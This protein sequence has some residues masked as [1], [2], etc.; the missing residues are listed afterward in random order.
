MGLNEKVV[1]TAIRQDLN[2]VSSAIKTGQTVTQK[3]V[4]QGRTL[5]YNAHKLPNGTVNVGRIHA[6]N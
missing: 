5:Q 2:A 4:V 3:I 6:A 1:E